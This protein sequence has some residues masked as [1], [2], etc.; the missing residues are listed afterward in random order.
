[1]QINSILFDMDG[2]LIDTNELIIESFKHTF[3][4]YDLTFTREEIM[5][6]NGPPLIDTFS[7]ILPDKTDDMIQ[8]YRKHNFANHAMY[9]KAFPYVR[10]V[11]EKLQAENVKM[12]IVSTKVRNSIQLG[13]KDAGLED[14]F[15]TIVGLD[16]VK[17]AKPHPESIYQAMEI[18]GAE[19]E[20]TLMI[21][22][23]YHDIEAGQNAGI[24]T[25]GVAWSMKDSAFLQAYHPTYMLED[26]RD[27]LKLT[28]NE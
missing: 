7:S 24:R 28:E 4:E 27:I 26:M 5:P 3:Q 15:T 12:A 13:L 1:M 20:T 17:H 21:G 23:N 11:I 6:F 19:K 16:D 22:D 9:V 8:T 18:I 25:A 14:L 2:T 10:E